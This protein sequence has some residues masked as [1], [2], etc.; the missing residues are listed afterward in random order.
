MSEVDERSFIPN[1]DGDELLQALFSAS[2]AAVVAIDLDFRVIA[3]NPAAQ[4]LFGWTAEEVI[5]T[6]PP[7]IP[8]DDKHEFFDAIETLRTGGVVAPY[9]C[10]R[11]RRDGTQI[12]VTT[13]RAAIRGADATVRGMVLTIV[14]RRSAVAMQR[15]ADEMEALLAFM[16][17]GAP[18]GFV[19]FDDDLKIQRM[20]ATFGRMVRRAPETYLGHGYRVY[21]NALT[22][23]LD[24]VWI[25]FQTD[26]TP[27]MSAEYR[28]DIPDAEGNLQHWKASLWPVEI[29]GRLAGMGAVIEDVADD[30]KRLDE[31]DQLAKWS[32]EQ[33]ERLAMV[34]ESTPSGLAVY[35]EAGNLTDANQAAITMMGGTGSGNLSMGDFFIMRGDGR[36]MDF[37]ESPSRRALAGEAVSDAELLIERPDRTIARLRASAAPFFDSTGAVSGAVV[38]FEDITERHRSNA[39][40][41]TIAALSEAIA[42]VSDLDRA[43]DAAVEIIT[44]ELADRCMIALVDDTGGMRNAARRPLETVE[45]PT[46]GGGLRMATHMVAEYWRTGRYAPVFHSDLAKVPPRTYPSSFSPLGISSGGM[47][48]S[49]LGV[50]IRGANGPVGAIALGM[51]ERGRRFVQEDVA[52]AE[53]V[54]ERI[55]TAIERAAVLARQRAAQ[56]QAERLQ[57]ALVAIGAASTQHDVARAV[58]ELGGPA[59]GAVMAGVTAVDP[60]DPAMLVEL[61]G[62]DYS[63]VFDLVHTRFVVAPGTPL[64]DAVYYGQPVILHNRRE[65]DL[66]YPDL[67]PLMRL[68]EFALA[69]LPFQNRGE[70]F[71]ALWLLFG[72]AKVFDERDHVE[73]VGFAANVADALRRA[74]RHE[75]EHDAAVALQRSL[76]PPSLLSTGAT[77]VAAR[78]LPAAT[79]LEVGGDF[80][81]VIALDGEQRLLVVGDVVGHGLDAA[82][83]MGQLR[84]AVQALAF[85][86]TTSA[87]LQQLDRF[88]ERNQRAWFATV[89]CV[90]LDPERGQLSYSLAGHPPPL[91]RFASGEVVELNQATGMPLGAEERERKQATLPFCEP[92]TVVLYSDGLIER[93]GESIDDG[94]GRLRQALISSDVPSANEACDRM[95]AAGLDGYH[96]RDDV[97]VL[98]ASTGPVTNRVRATFEAVPAAL[99]E[100]RASVRQWLRQWSPGVDELHDIVLA[101]G[102][103]CSNAVEH[104]VAAS[105]L[106]VS[107]EFAHEPSGWVTVTVAD[108]GRWNSE[109][110][111]PD[112]GRGVMLMRRIMDNVDINSSPTGTVVMLR[113]R[114]TPPSVDD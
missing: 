40:L 66:A 7:I 41:R 74:A 76:L 91:V 11:L 112:R 82:I 77:T 104:P 56:L 65:F 9:D 70:S 71:G 83:A 98:C 28:G 12:P 3:W 69:V 58:V 27:V 99:A 19:Y 93:R 34:L 59:F 30:W 85:A 75:S 54:A 8:D 89:A 111:G 51:T 78:Y 63:A 33:S 45:S 114:L 90:V 73:L 21:S 105:A 88:V 52:V 16:W 108:T 31:L 107:L 81:D 18:I 42:D 24:R 25:R 101:V 17:D 14:D 22:S 4:A 6:V 10:L 94:L 57:E 103:A 100:M 68:G 87:L 79:S 1:R 46:S 102:E 44:T 37:T 113:K 39:A 110:S 64:T 20:N 84:S 23:F 43:L 48:R 106:E 15:R 61:S 86:P 49:F 26:R 55:G 97:A 72:A 60:V 92:V 62:R 95:V 50:L 80:F 96:Q 36:P 38:A 53:A 2:S 32:A 47:I 109:P 29:D 5:G 13:S 35:D 67:T